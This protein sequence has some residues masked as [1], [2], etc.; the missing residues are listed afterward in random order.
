VAGTTSDAGKSVFTTG[1]CRLLARRGVQVAP[2][3]AQNMSNNSMVVAGPD[4]M[5]A[6]IGRAQWIQAIAAGVTPEVA[7]NPVL[8]K[9]GSDRRSHI[10]L[11]GHPAG[12][13]SSVEFVGG[14]RALAE[15]A[16]AAYA[17]LAG[18][19]EVVVCEGAGSP[20]EINLRAHDY[21]NMGLARHA[22][23]PV[24]VVGDID[25]GGLYAALYGTVALLEPEDQ[26]LVAGFVVNKF[27]GEE[28]LLHPA[29]RE[30]TR[31]TGRPVLGVVPWSP[32]VWLDSEDALDTTGRTATVADP[33]RVGVVRFPRISNFTDVDALGL[34]PDV[35]V[36]FAT[37]PADLADADLIVLPGTRSTIADLA[38]FRRRGLAD[39][40][41]AHA[42][43]GRPV[44]GVCGGFQMLGTVVD[45]P[46]GV[47]S[48]PGTRVDGL[49]LLDT[50]T[51]FAA[52]KVVRLSSG[53]ALGAAVRGYA[54]HHGVV[55]GGGE[56]FFGGIRQGNV[57]GTM[58]HGS[59]ESDGFRA[60][61]LAEVASAVGRARTPS[62]IRFDEAR[63]R[64]LDHL[65]DLIEQHVDVDAVLRL[66]DGGPPPG[67]PVLAPGD[68]RGVTA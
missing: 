61:F 17:D 11:N 15:A 33:L 8:L 21:V 6:E 38:W 1:L 30:I 37:R 31:L 63:Q 49:A 24:L 20:T 14:R 56:D 53:M 66:I 54:I 4:G 64:R 23:M 13:I 59:L 7:M 47:E 51:V 32:E 18:R 45:D 10:V 26:R 27:R 16:F 39:A 57:F 62:G 41:A 29:N 40:V 52:E 3:K 35:E 43:S 12:S 9:P 68:G 28:A 50:R 65:A 55:T 2:F 25:R 22:G 48:P 19:F 36:R 42:A 5:G 44:L 60:A 58:W 67:L 34:E 46:D